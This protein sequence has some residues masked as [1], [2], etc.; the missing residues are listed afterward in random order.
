MSDL[1]D[2]AG[3]A[4]P[5]DDCCPP[6]VYAAQITDGLTGEVMAEG[7]AYLDSEGH[8]HFQ[9]EKPADAPLVVEG[10]M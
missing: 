4:L 5:C 3:P 9:G 2:C 6:I 7:V 8:L 10:G 1:P